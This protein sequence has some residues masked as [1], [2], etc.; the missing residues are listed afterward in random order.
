MHMELQTEAV[1]M[2]S[3]HHTRRLTSAGS[4]QEMVRHAAAE[5]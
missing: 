4:L 2:Q 3:S 1:M 5:C